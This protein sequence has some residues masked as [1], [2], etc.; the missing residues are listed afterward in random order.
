MVRECSWYDTLARCIPEALPHAL[1]KNPGTLLRQPAKEA[2]G[3][4]SKAAKDF[5]KAHPVLAAVIL[6]I[7]AL[8]VLVAATWPWALEAFGFGKLGPTPGIHPHSGAIALR[9]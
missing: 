9:C 6:I 5:V 1:K 7:I 3:H 4:F 8:G 2:L